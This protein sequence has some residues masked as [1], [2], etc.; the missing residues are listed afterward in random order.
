MERRFQSVYVIILSYPSV[1]S[2]QLPFLQK[3]VRPFSVLGNTGSAVESSEPLFILFQS[4]I[5]SICKLRT[6]LEA[7]FMCISN[8]LTVTDYISVCNFHFELG[9]KQ[10]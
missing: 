3:Y 8:L 4:C 5:Q 7:A 2:V 1:S 10:V 9:Q 6:N